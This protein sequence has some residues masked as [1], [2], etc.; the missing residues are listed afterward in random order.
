MEMTLESASRKI[1]TCENE[2]VQVFKKALDLAK[3]I[4]ECSR[5]IEMLER[6][7][8]GMFIEP[9]PSGALTRGRVE[10]LPT[11]RNFYV[12]DPRALPTKASWIIGVESA[13]RL[14]E[15]YKLR[16]GKYPES[17]GFILWSIDAYKADGEQLAQILY[18][19]GVEPTW[20]ESGYVKELRVISAVEASAWRGSED[21]A[22][23]WI[24]WSGYAY[25]RK[26]FGENAHDVLVLNLEKV[27]MVSRNHS[28]DEHDI[29][30][31]CC[32]FAYHGG[33][34]NA[35]KTISGKD[36][37]IVQV[38]T[39]DISNIDIHDM[40][41]EIERIVRAKLLNPVWIEEMKKHGYRGANEIQRKILHL[42]GWSATTKLVNDW[43]FNEI[44]KT[45]ALDEEMKK[46][47]IE[48][49]IYALEE[50]VR[51]L[52]EAAERKL[53][54]PDPELL[55]KLRDIHAEIEGY[56]EESITGQDYQGG[57]IVIIT[58]EQDSHWKENIK[59]VEQ[60]MERMRKIR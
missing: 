16:M 53:W 27:D 18:L 17:V 43:I 37:L 44:A 59:N 20:S 36:I 23:I 47:F 12:V 30:A 31:C 33:F 49:N 48:N 5:E 10:I 25:S 4:E 9:G 7:V 42:Y 41:F 51:R 21:L 19:L 6:G 56:L 35:V 34:Y 24:H 32:Y 11:G 13:K 58:S 28:S 15:H 50:I 46:W 55:N 8:S 3:R 26:S 2:L 22:K 14:L 54:K 38:D 57:S 52:I 45:Y 40:K 29:F 1:R 39:R 60:V